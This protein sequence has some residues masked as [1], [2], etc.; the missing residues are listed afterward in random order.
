MDCIEEKPIK[1]AFEAF[2][3]AEYLSD[4]RANITQESLLKAGFKQNKSGLFVSP[5]G[6]MKVKRIVNSE[7]R[8]KFI[9]PITGENMVG[10][11]TQTQRSLGNKPLINY[12]T[13]RMQ[14]GGRVNNYADDSMTI[15]NHTWAK[16]A[17]APKQYEGVLRNLPDW[18]TKGAEAQAILAAL[19]SAGVSGADRLASYY[20]QDVLAHINPT[21]T[22]TGEVYTKVWEAANLMKDSQLYN[23]FLETIKTRKDIQSRGGLVAPHVVEAVMAQTGLPQS[24]VVEELQKLSGGKHPN[25]RQGA[26]T[27][28][29]LARI[30][31]QATKAGRGLPIGVAAGMQARLQ[32][33]FYETLQSRALSS[34]LPTV[35]V[36]ATNSGAKAPQSRSGIIMPSGVTGSKVIYP[37]MAGGGDRISGT[38]ATVN[39][40]P[41]GKILSSTIDDMLVTSASGQPMAVSSRELLA[42]TP[43]GRVAG[44]TSPG[45]EA[46]KR[47]VHP[48]GTS[49]VRG[50]NF[51]AKSAADGT[52]PVYM[53]PIQGG[54]MANFAASL[55][56]MVGVVGQLQFAFET[57]TSEVSNGT[58][59]WVAG[60]ELGVSSLQLFADNGMGA[61]G[62]KLKKKGDVLSRANS[63]YGD[64]GAKGS[65]IG[66]GS[67]AMSGIGSAMSKVASGLSNPLVQI[68]LQLGMAAI[69]KSIQ[70]YN[71]EMEKAKVAGNGAFKEP[72]ETAKLLGVQLKSLTDSA[73]KY[74]KAN[75]AIFGEQGRGAYDKAF[76]KTIKADYGDFIGSLKDT[77]TE[78]EKINQLTNAYTSLI[79]RGM[80]PKNAKEMTAEIARQA[81]TLSAY[82]KASASLGKIKDSKG[83]M[84]AQLDTMTSQID[85]LEKRRKMVT[86]GT[87]TDVGQGLLG[88][89]TGGLGSYIGGRSE[90][91]K[92][93]ADTVNKAIFGENQDKW[94]A[95]AL[96]GTGIDRNPFVQVLGGWLA[97]KKLKQQIASQLGATLKSAF[98]MAADNPA[99]ASEAIRAIVQQFKTA[100]WGTLSKE[101]KDILKE[102]GF[103]DSSELTK[104]MTS[105]TIDLTNSVI[106]SAKEGNDLLQQ[107]LFEI[108]NTGRGTDL[109]KMLKDGKLNP[110][111]KEFKTLVGEVAKTKALVKIEAEVDLQLE[112]TKKQLEGL[113]DATQKVFEAAIEAKQKE[114]E[115]EDKR[116][117]AALGNLDKEAEKIG[118]K[119]DLLQEN[120]DYYLKELQ[121][122]KDAEDYYANQ[123]NTALGG[124]KSLS[125]GDVFGFIGAQ[126][127]AASQADQ[128]GRDQSLKTIQ[129][130]A[131]EEQKKLD[132][133][134]KGIDDRKKA[135][136]ARH[137]AEMDNIN[138]EIL[139]LRKKESQSVGQI[140]EALSLIEKAEKMTAGDKGFDKAVRTAN[141]AARQA[142]ITA[143]VNTEGLKLPA[144]T[145]K[146]TLKA[147]NSAKGELKDALDIMAGDTVS[148]V[149]VLNQS[150]RIAS[151]VFK[152]MG[153]D[154]K[155]SKEYQGVFTTLQKP[156]DPK[157][158][159]AIELFMYAKPEWATDSKGNDITNVATPTAPTTP[160]NPYNMSQT[161]LA[162][163]FGP[164]SKPAKSGYYKT[165]NGEKLYWNA[166]TQK[167]RKTATFETPF[168]QGTIPLVKADGGAIYGAGTATSDSIPAMLSNGEYVVK[169]SSVSKYGVPFM[170]AINAGRYA[171]G[172]GVGVMPRTS[173]PSS[174][175]YSVPS[176]PSVSP[177]S[178]AGLAG[179]GG[180]GDMSSN[181]PTYN[182]N[183]NGAGM[184]MVMG[185]VNKAM[186]G[187]IGNNSRGVYC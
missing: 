100:D 36:V 15:R 113:K 17:S 152:S 182:F 63:V 178:I 42:V 45:D 186:G 109:E 171:G 183:F 177:A 72:T 174:P 23:V 11:T 8:A 88:A 74:A 24:V 6:K 9:D 91:Q 44:V 126:Q 165:E 150:G 33:D 133:A 75:K 39:V 49:L 92:L 136:D 46:R 22:N 102:K 114:L 116:H 34:S 169:A 61:L 68:G 140:N 121:R 83:A 41:D 51:R 76:E 115:A 155:T 13:G 120:T 78:Q 179:G 144:G 12:L 139:A 131:D 119:K 161:E 146:E 127:Q 95:K 156:L 66:A 93:R 149:K 5:D 73:E 7:G 99:A 103:G 98:S 28:L 65:L 3:R 170:N 157:T 70:I 50:K 181:T 32:G 163:G 10:P 134:L 21:S 147:F 81:G 172:G 123:R 184:D 158:K 138:A 164:K 31:P 43:D 27:M 29:A 173:V 137:Q 20:V 129:D 132:N 111:S 35:K 176:T 180:M 154:P 16:K 79:Q 124:L 97:D 85:I 84:S 151:N 25:T 60:I 37:S 55:T 167:W 160:I 145:D 26:M 175:T 82:N 130:T 54:S 48:F 64:G 59:K 187:T 166:Q 52:E 105:D 67:K 153:I 58:Q 71:A 117:E 122:E 94:W 19:Q 135:E 110:N 57:F 106:D 101:I 89:V 168:M 128:F 38:G 56:S 2:K 47:I 53:G 80:D 30:F 162:D 185:H 141:N 4:Y 143:R 104:F 90:G 118:K 86:A 87:G 62:D 108:I 18:A 142:G 69:N 107:Q 1:K 14:S 40:G 125:S 112:D 96:T 77:Q 159:D 148:A